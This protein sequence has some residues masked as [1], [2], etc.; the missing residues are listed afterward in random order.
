MN[1]KIITIS[2]LLLLATVSCK[3][4]NEN[5]NEEHQHEQTEV[6]KEHDE[7]DATED[8]L[9]LNKGEKW[10][11][12]EEMLPYILK[13]EQL[14]E[15]FE[16][17]DY[18]VLADELMESNNNLITS[19][20]MDGPSHDVLHKWLHPHIELLKQLKALANQ[21]EAEEV[22]EEIEDSFE[23]FHVYFK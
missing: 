19:C 9:S 23:V 7:S 6:H 21:E 13:S 18:N 16:G 3:N 12:N 4:N 10:N 5:K 11:V 20:T 15:D 1:S 8:E 22:V 14:V 17:E 2:A